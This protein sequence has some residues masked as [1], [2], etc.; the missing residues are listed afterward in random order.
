[1]IRFCVRKTRLLLP[2]LRGTIAVFRRSP[3]TYTRLLIQLP[4]V[5]RG[6]SRSQ[7]DRSFLP[8]C[9]GSDHETSTTSSNPLKSYFNAHEKGRGI[10]KWIHYFDIYMRHFDRFVGRDVHI[11][12]IGIYSGG[13]L[14]MWRHFFGER[15]HVYGV[16]I[17]A[18]CRVYENDYTRVFI[19]DQADRAFW[20]SVRGQVPVIDIVI[21][22]GGHKT[23]QQV[24]TLEETL[25]HLAPGGVYLCED[26]HFTNNDFAAYAYGLVKCLNDLPCDDI[27]AGFAPSEFQKWIDGI[28]FYPF[29]IVIE[30]ARTPVS[31]FLAP[32][33]G[34]EW[35]P[36]L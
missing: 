15:C 12:E 18:S 25:P 14:E 1:M 20:K 11:L 35:Q 9:A 30:K 5:F 7:S 33:R 24:V 34:T 4:F 6:L 16:D 2:Y 21:D 10:W 3:S 8:A 17:E 26:V 36:F 13:S 32:K 28:H 22:D 31:R 27:I 23:E 19:G 29:A